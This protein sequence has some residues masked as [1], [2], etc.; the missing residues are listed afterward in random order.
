MQRGVFV[1]RVL[2][3]GELGGYEEAEKAIRATLATLR[4]RLAGNEPTTSPPRSPAISP[5]PY[6]ARADA[7]ASRSP[8][9]TAGS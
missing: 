9:S 4:E 3:M 7:K 1:K 8:S 2:E 6:G 5:I